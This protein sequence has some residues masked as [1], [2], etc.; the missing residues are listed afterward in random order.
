MHCWKE[1]DWCKKQYPF[2]VEVA[3]QTVRNKT[4]KKQ[5]FSYNQSY[6]NYIKITML[7]IEIKDESEV[8][9]EISEPIKT[10]EIKN[11]IGL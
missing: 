7:K 2:S 8:L 9:R 5:V 4:R 6:L 3:N 10:N 1:R 11:Y